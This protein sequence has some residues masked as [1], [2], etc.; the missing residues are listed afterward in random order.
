[1]KCLK[2][3]NA[4]NFHFPIRILQQKFGF[5]PIFRSSRHRPLIIIGRLRCTSLM[6]SRLI[7]QFQPPPPPLLLLLLLLKSWKQSTWKYQ[8][9]S[10]C[11][12]H[13]VYPRHSK[14]GTKKEAKI[15]IIA[16]STG[17]VNHRP[18]RQD[19]RTVGQLQAIPIG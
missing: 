14:M 12:Q 13:Q 8:N 5:C 2:L 9:L 18:L 6:M 17:D 4:L 19:A 3:A 11:R 16:T 15:V 1:M 7:I 10:R